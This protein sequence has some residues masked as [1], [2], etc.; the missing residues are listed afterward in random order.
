MNRRLATGLAL[1]AAVALALGLYQRDR[2]S[3]DTLQISP[4]DKPEPASAGPGKTRAAAASAAAALP[5][6]GG[7]LEP[8]AS[9]EQ[10]ARETFERSSLKT[11]RDLRADL[12]ALVSE[13]K[14]LPAQDYEPRARD[15]LARV[16]VLAADGYLTAA[17]ALALRLGLLGYALPPGDYRTAANRLIGEARERAEQAEREWAARSDPRHEYYRAEERRIVEQS[18][19]MGEFPHGMTRQAYLRD[20]L[21]DLRSE[22]YSQ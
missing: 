5:A 11:I 8:A 3:P 10:L 2:G 21:R 17:E 14:L 9:F 18:A 4:G 19:A 16:E 20:K 13:A 15:L 7:E 12:Q 1:F 22:I 6:P